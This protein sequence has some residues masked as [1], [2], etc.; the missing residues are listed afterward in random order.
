MIHESGY[1]LGL[2]SRSH[3]GPGWPTLT[4]SEGKQQ[5][6]AQHS[7]VPLAKRFLEGAM[8]G[9]VGTDCG[10]VKGKRPSWGDG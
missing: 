2:P 1:C 4:E 7:I 10:S 8:A 5:G 6:E 3:R 9:W